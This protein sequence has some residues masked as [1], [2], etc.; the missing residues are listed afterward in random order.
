MLA[1]FVECP[2]LFKMKLIGKWAKNLWV[3]QGDT[4][5]VIGTFSAENEFYLEMDDQQPEPAAR[6][7]Y[8]KRHAQLVIVEPHILI[9]TTQIVKAFPCVRKAF[10]SSQ[11][12]GN[13]G[14]VNYALVLGNV[15]H[16]VF[17]VIL[18]QMDFKLET[19]DGIIK[20]AIK[21]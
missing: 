20:T 10:L 9:P 13:S 17:Q 15:I 16:E 2:I 6:A 12:K 1:D 18:Q 8:A 14:D 21:G 4:V 5:R 3:S 19:L 7:E 11:F